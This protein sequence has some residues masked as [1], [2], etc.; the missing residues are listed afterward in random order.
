[1]TTSHGQ[2]HFGHPAPNVPSA[3]S[4]SEKAIAAL[5]LVMSNGAGGINDYAA[6]RSLEASRLASL[7]ESLVGEMWH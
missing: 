6:V 4:L 5:T 3:A 7:D 2:E 1:M